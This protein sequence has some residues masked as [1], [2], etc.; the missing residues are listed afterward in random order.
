MVVALNGTVGMIKLGGN[1]PHWP[2]GSARID[3]YG[4]RETDR[5]QLAEK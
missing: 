4:W 2:L 1:G 5:P 3:G